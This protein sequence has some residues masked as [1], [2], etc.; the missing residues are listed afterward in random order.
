[1][2]TATTTGQYIKIIDVKSG[3]TKRTIKFS[4]S[5]IQG[6]IVTDKEMSITVRLNPSLTYV[7]VYSLPHGSLKRRI[8]I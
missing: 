8:R 3:S 7:L 4:G 6:P 5:L 1:M 2:H